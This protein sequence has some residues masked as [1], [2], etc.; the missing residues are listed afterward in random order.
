M[1]TKKES[2]VISLCRDA[3]IDV[4]KNG[5]VEIKVNFDLTEILMSLNLYFS[6]DLI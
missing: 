2:Y 3:K 6:P 4:T 5:N 1:E